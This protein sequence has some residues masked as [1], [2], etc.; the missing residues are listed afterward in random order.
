MPPSSSSTPLTERQSQ[1]L[2]LVQLGLSNKEVARELKISEG[3]VKQ[4]LLEVYRRLNVTNRTMAAEVGRR[5]DSLFLPTTVEKGGGVRAKSGKSLPALTFP[6][7]TAAMQPVTLVKVVIQASEALVNTLGSRG[8]A[9]FNHMFREIC[10]QE[11]R[12]FEGALQGTPDGLLLLFGTPHLREDDPERAACCAHRIFHRTRQHWQEELDAIEFPLRICVFTGDLVI[13]SDGD[14]TTLHGALLVHTSET[15]AE[16]CR[17]W[18]APCVDAT[19]R[20]ALTKLAG[21]YGQVPLPVP[22]GCLDLAP[23]PDLPFFGRTAELASLRQHKDLLLQGQSR[24]VVILGEAGFGKTR[25]VETFQTEWPSALP[26][27]WLAGRCRPAAYH[28][29]L[30]PLF[31]ILETL[32]GCSPSD[33]ASTRSGERLHQWVQTLPKPLVQPGKALIDWHTAAD[34]ALTSAPSNSRLVAAAE[35]I[36]GVLR[37]EPTATVVFLDNLQWAD[38]ATHA[39]LPLLVERLNGSAVWLLGAGRKAELRQLPAHTGMEPL[40][41]PKLSTRFLADLL[42]RMLPAKIIQD[43]TLFHL[44]RWCRGVPLFAVEI[45]KH[46]QHIPDL[47]TVN[48]LTENDFF[49]LSLQGLILERIQGAGIDWRTARAIAAG[50]KITMSQLLALELHAEPNLTRSAAARLSQVGLLETSG[51]GPGQTLTFINGMVRAA[52]WHTLPEEDKKL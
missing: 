38:P 16:H 43:A 14:K 32:A 23:I 46:L 28:F 18:H 41:L 37:L 9:R 52:I 40:P 35:F 5:A 49:P 19:T 47:S 21:R 48:N 20:H 2:R 6:R 17:E 51:M 10:Q 50:G 42:R 15:M 26:V 3:T 25:L 27:R 7:F 24:S 8:F 13:N 4:H 39:L 29:P 11:S 44:A 36:T 22:E 45:A 1:I 31:A 30:H 34:P 12:R 33:P